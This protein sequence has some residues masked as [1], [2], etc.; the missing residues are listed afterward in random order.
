[1]SIPSSTVRKNLEKGA[2]SLSPRALARLS[3]RLK[4]GIYSDIKALLGSTFISAKDICSLEEGD[5]VLLDS[6]INDLVHVQ[7]NDCLKLFGQPGIKNDR[8]SVRIFSNAARRQERFVEPLSVVE[9][10]RREDVP[11]YEDLPLDRQDSSIEGQMAH[12]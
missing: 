5:V 2:S 8:I 1:M 7:V 10:P 11:A 6:N 3:D 4:G 12:F 9:E